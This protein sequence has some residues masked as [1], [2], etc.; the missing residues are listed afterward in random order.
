[1]DR[2]KISC[3]IPVYN[4][5]PRVL[6]VIKAVHDSGVVDEIIVVDDGSKD[7]TAQLVSEFV[8]GLQGI[9]FIT[10]HPNRGKSHAVKVGFEAATND[11]VMMI[12]SDL[13]G[14]NRDCLNAL[15]EPVRNGQADVT[16]SMRDNSLGIYKALGLDF[17]SGERVF[18]KDLI[19]DL[20]VLD[21]LT[22]FGLES[23]MNQII[24][25]KKL[26]I[27]VVMWKGVI[28]PRKSVKAGWWV[29]MIGD[30]K[31]SLEIIS[32]LGIFG[33]ARVMMQ[34]RKLRV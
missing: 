27:K 18:K 16:I 30:I 4:E 14:L 26:R 6:N 5:G 24:I 15:A 21:K 10:Y 31:M 23:Y 11:Y 2:I 34:M 8:T 20:S 12:D 28:S 19:P 25:E 7:N 13:I 29:G 33:V 3:I 1:M 22:G 32:L 9:N 17:I